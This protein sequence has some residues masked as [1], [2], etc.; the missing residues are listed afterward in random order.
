MCIPLWSFA[1][2]NDTLPE[3][4]IAPD[5]GWL[6]DEISFWDGLFSGAMLVSGSVGLGEISLKAR[7]YSTPEPTQKMVRLEDHKQ[8]FSMFAEG[9]LGDA[10]S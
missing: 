7:I 10:A 1:H 5:N 4:K 2:F 8:A 3:T 9:F 6:K